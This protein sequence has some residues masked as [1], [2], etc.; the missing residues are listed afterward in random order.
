MTLAWPKGINKMNPLEITMRLMMVIPDHFKTYEMCNETV[1]IEPLSLEYVPYCFKTQ[2]MCNEAVVH[3]PYTM[4]FIP[5]HPRT[6]EM[7]NDIWRINPA[8]FSL[9]FDRF[10]AQECEKAVE[11]DPWQLYNVPDRFKTQNRYNYG[12]MMTIIIMMRLLSGT[13]TIKNARPRNKK[14]S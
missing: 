4:R 11:V 12:M 8:T 9:I 2:G 10:K 7:C 13:K 3:N 14:K 5:D 6:Q 1:H